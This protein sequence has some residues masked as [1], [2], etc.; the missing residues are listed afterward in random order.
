LDAATQFVKPE[1]FASREAF[2]AELRRLMIEPTTPSRAV[3]SIQE[4]QGAQR[5]WLLRNVK[6]CDPIG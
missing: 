2:L 6:E 4:Y 5:R 3:P 1:F